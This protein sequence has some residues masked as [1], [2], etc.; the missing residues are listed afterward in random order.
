MRRVLST[1]LPLVGILALP[2][3]VSAWASGEGRSGNSGKTLTVVEH[4]TTDTT[5]DTGAAGDTVSDVLTF[6][7]EV[8]NAADT[9]KV[10]TDQGYCIRVVKGAAYE[11]NW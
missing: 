9:T 3:A 10:G 1:A 11:C 5:T 2:P 6:A 7:N 8:F 4:A